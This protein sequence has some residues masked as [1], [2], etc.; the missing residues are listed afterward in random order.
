MPR[1]P[2]SAAARRRDSRRRRAPP[3]ARSSAGLR[4]IARAR[5]SESSGSASAAPRQRPAVHRRGGRRFGALRQFPKQQGVDRGRRRL[6][7]VAREPGRKLVRGGRVVTAKIA[8]GED[9]PEQRRDRSEAGLPGRQ[10]SISP[11]A[12]RAK[13]RWIRAASLGA[14]GCGSAAPPLVGGA[15][16][17]I[18]M[19]FSSPFPPSDCC[20]CAA[21]QAAAVRIATPGDQGLGSW[22]TGKGTTDGSHDG[23]AYTPHPR[24]RNPRSRHEFSL[25]ETNRSVF[26]GF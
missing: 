15:T 20:A 17:G 1:S 6:V 4:A 9:V 10:Y 24:W 16:R 22:E 8:V 12:C 14:S 13:M 21:G 19:A 18:A 5:G 2:R 26:S 3:T 11:C 25:F 23:G 7:G